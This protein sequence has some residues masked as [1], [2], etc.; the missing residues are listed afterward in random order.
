VIYKLMTT[1]ATYDKEILIAAHLARLEQN[2][3]A[4]A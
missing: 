4:A 3:T 2:Q 1:D